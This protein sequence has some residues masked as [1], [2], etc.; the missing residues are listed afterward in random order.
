VEQDD[1]RRTGLEQLLR[2]MGADEA[3]AS[4]DHKPSACDVHPCPPPCSLMSSPP[5]TGEEDGL[6]SCLYAEPPPSVLP[7]TG[8]EYARWGGH[9]QAD[10]VA[11]RTVSWCLLSCNWHLSPPLF[12]SPPRRLC[13][14]FL[15]IG[16]R[17]T[18][19]LDLISLVASS[20]GYNRGEIEQR[21]AH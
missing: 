4:R 12:P 19:C 9:M 21:V 5:Q 3:G 7:S 1:C 15:P 16:H 20:C 11:M 2:E 13:T 17:P 8:M 18:V 10:A 6:R 14:L